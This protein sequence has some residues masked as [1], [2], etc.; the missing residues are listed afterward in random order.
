MPPKPAPRLYPLAPLLEVAARYGYVSKHGH[1]YGPLIELCKLSGRELCHARER[2]LTEA[3]ADRCAVRLGLH[4]SAVWG[5]EWWDGIE[6]QDRTALL[7]VGLRRELAV[8]QA[9]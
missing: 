6:A 3:Q 9:G 8:R 7:F 2:G 1:R 5:E 4:P